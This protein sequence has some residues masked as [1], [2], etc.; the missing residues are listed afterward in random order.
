MARLEDQSDLP[1]WKTSYPRVGALQG[2]EV[3]AG[4]TS[5][6][7]PGEWA[8]RAGADVAREARAVRR[9]LSEGQLPEKTCSL[10]QFEASPKAQPAAE[11]AKAAAEAWGRDLPYDVGTGSHGGRG[12]TSRS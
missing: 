3:T 4:A 6:S 11:A 12:S 5:A 1:I 10:R 7:A 9:C 2:S 8:H